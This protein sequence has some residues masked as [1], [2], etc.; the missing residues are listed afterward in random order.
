LQ[1]AVHY[2]E[3]HIPGGLKEKAE[4]MFGAAV[5]QVKGLIK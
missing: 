1:K 4:E 2:A 5:D 3:D